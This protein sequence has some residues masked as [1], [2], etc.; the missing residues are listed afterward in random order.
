MDIVDDAAKT[1]LRTLLNEENQRAIA[2]AM[3]STSAESLREPLTSK[4]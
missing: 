2:T 1:Y 4:R 3:R